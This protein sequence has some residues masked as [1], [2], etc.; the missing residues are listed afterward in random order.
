MNVRM[1]QHKYEVTTVYGEK[2][3]F[4][5][6]ERNALYAIDCYQRIYGQAIDSIVYRGEIKL[7]IWR[8]VIDSIK[9]SI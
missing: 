2:R 3:E 4:V 9:K 5:I 7:P 8:R 6:G 1:I